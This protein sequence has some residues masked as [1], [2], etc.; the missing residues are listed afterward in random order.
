MTKPYYFPR[1]LASGIVNIIEEIKVFS[2]NLKIKATFGGLHINNP[3]NK[4]NESPCYIMK[5]TDTL[6]E[7][8]SVFYTGHCTGEINFCRIKEMLGNKIRT[9]N[10][11]EVIE[12]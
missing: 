4:K 12:V 2:K 9:M 5:L 7:I 1:M 8:D 11:G 3:L 6:G 10:T